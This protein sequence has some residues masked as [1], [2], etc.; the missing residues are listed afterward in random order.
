MRV[1]KWR[2]WINYTVREVGAML[3]IIVNSKNF[4][5]VIV[6]IPNRNR[7]KKIIPLLL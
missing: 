6:K 2:L 5:T 4:V 1:L 3:Q 7:D